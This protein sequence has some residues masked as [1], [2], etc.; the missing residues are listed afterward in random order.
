MPGPRPVSP[1]R[2]QTAPTQPESRVGRGASERPVKETLRRPLPPVMLPTAPPV[3]PVLPHAEHVRQFI[4]V[5]LRDDDQAVMDFAL[6]LVE[7]GMSPD[8]LY[9]EVFAESARV[10]GDMWCEDDC[11]FYDVTVGAGRIHRLIREFSHQFQAEQRYPGGTGRILLA[12]AADEQHSLGI[13][14]LA[15]FFVRD[16][17]DVHIGPGLGSEAL[18]DKVR[19]SDYDILGFSVAVTARISKLQQDIRRA[20]QVSRKRDIQVLV[21][22]QL[23]FADPSLTQRIGANGYALDARSAVREARRL[24]TA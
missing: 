24:I 6:G 10:L 4:A 7:N 22:G 2:A 16:G 13:A 3:L 19:E 23:I 5:L 20:R 14:L 15:E 21:G 18:L 12:C 9:E 11:S 1:Q 17:W 8:A